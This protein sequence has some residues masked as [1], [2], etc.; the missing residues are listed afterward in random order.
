MRSLKLKGMNKKGVLGMDTVRDVIVFMLTLSVT[1]IAVFLALSSLQ[2]ANLFTGGSTEELNTNLTIG[3]ITEGTTAFFSNIPTVF[4]ILG[5][6]VIILAVTLILFAV[7][8][9]GKGTGN[10]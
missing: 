5:A 3:N 10:L 7:N 1:A 8:R 9:F 6:V 2:N 4:T